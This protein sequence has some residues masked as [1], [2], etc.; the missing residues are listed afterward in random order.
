MYKTFIEP[1]LKTAH[2]RIVNKLNPFT[3]FESPTY[4]LKELQALRVY[5]EEVEKTLGTPIEVEP[6]NE[7]KREKVGLN[8]NQ[9]THFSSREVPSF[10]RLEPQPLLNS[11]SLD[12]NDPKRHYGF[13]PGLLGKSVSLGVDILNWEMF[14]DNRGLESKVVSP[15]KE[16]LSLFD[17][18]NEVERGRILEAHC[19]GI[20]L[21]EVMTGKKPTDEM[22]ND[23][24]N[25]KKVE[26]CLVAIIKVGV[27]C[28]VDSPPQRMKTEII[29]IELQ[30]ILDVLQNI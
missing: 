15:L 8:C 30:R 7:T 9:N 14:D 1:D 20:L 11:P 10:D 23:E 22:F 24:A 21:L 28:S 26:E 13:K 16:E 29:V 27:S 5:P 12:V 3:G 25:A 6:L 4:I 17:R 18:P 19:F 2:I